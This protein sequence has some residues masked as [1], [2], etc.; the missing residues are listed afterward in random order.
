MVHALSALHF[1]PFNLAMTGG[2]LTHR[3]QSLSLVEYARQQWH[4]K[5]NSEDI[6][7]P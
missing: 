5:R 6:E 4:S 3:N 7:D 1:G 2:G